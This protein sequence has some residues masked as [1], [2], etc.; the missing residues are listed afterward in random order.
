M[1]VTALLPVRTAAPGEPLL[2]VAAAKEHLRVE[3]SDEDDLIEA[4]CGAVE[5]YLDGFAGILGRA[6]VT[7]SWS[8]SFDCFPCG[9]R[10]ALPIGPLQDVDSVM[11]YD[12]D[13][14]HLAFGSSN[15]HAVTD[16]LGPCIILADLAQWPDTAVRPD[17]VTVTWTCGYGDA[18]EVPP[19]IAQAAKLMVGNLYENRE[20][21]VTGPITTELP[22]GA[23]MLLAPFRVAMLGG[24]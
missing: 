5:A 4:L 3:H 10:I 8:R 24:A 18:D 13:G 17:A 9:N 22:L 14:N 16:P 7:Q 19:P 11:Y 1:S 6:L 21:V 15:F 12:R 23:A 2:T 20:A